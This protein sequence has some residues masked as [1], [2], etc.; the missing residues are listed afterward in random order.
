MDA[1]LEKHVDD[2][3]EL[4][5]DVL[6]GGGLRLGVRQVHV[7]LPQPLLRPVVIV[8]EQLVLVV[9]LE[10]NERFLDDTEANHIDTVE[11]VHV[12][13]GR[14]GLEDEVDVDL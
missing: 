3:E 5:A 6:D 2:G 4:V 11:V 10:S 1:I 7:Q 13:L 8:D 12:N 9:I 14:Q